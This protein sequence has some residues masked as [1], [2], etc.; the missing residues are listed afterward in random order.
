MNT[1]RYKNFSSFF[2]VSMCDTESVL[3][4]TQPI[5]RMRNERHMVR[6]QQ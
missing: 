6:K 1:E 4:V 3:L 5:K 2:L